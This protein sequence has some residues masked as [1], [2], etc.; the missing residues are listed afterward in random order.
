[1]AQDK[2]KT[3]NDGKANLDEGT[4]VVPSLGTVGLLMCSSLSRRLGIY[5]VQQQCRAVTRLTQSHTH[6]HIYFCLCR[7]TQPYSR[8]TLCCL[9]SVSIMQVQ[10]GRVS[11]SG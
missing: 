10:L 8:R 9:R 7:V 5:V 1:M 3:S 6:R 11:W 4:L 2:D